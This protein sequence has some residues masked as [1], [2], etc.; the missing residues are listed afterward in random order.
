MSDLFLL[1]SVVELLSKIGQIFL[2]GTKAMKDQ[3]K[4]LGFTLKRVCNKAVYIVN[5]ARFE[6]EGAGHNRGGMGRRE[7][8]QVLHRSGER[9]EEE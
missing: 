2:V 7:I 8:R 5:D 6:L 9:D 4:P 1:Q 3:N